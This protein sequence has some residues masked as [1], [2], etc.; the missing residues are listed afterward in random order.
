MNLS[1]S[2]TLNQFAV[3]LIGFERNYTVVESVGSV[4][5]CAVVLFPAPDVPILFTVVLSV[6]TVEGTAGKY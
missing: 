5:V 1:L 4:D 2:Y 6:N 3:I